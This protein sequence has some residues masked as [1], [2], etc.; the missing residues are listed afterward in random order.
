MLGAVTH[1]VPLM[2][3]WLRRGRLATTFSMR[4]VM[5]PYC[6]GAK[7]PFSPK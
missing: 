5:E 3:L 7:L 6:D 4:G 2:S 1:I